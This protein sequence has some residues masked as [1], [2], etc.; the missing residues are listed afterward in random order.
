M[1]RNQ[2]GTRMSG[3]RR[4]AS[5][6]AGALLAVSIGGAAHALTYTTGDYIAVFVKG[7]TD[8]YVDLG[9]NLSSLNN[10]GTFLLPTPA[11]SGDFASGAAGATFALYETNAPF[12]G[13][14]PRGITI[15]TDPSVDPTTFNNKAS[16]ITKVTP[17]QVALDN[18]S[19]AGFLP[20]DVGTSVTNI[21]NDTF[22]L[23]LNNNSNPG[24]VNPN[25]WVS[26]IGANING[27]LPFSTASTLGAG[28]SVEN[29]YS[30]TRTGNATAVAA[31][32]GFFD[33]FADVSTPDGTAVTLT[34]SPIPEPG[35]LLLVA[36]GLTGLIWVGRRRTE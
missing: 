22:R 26:L 12:S 25:S 15:T 35:T 18:G 28:T 24:P 3:I 4:I 7:N 31:P 6:A 1:N 5:I 34:F 11:Q 17:A 8:F 21:L 32:L 2:F 16:L 23:A 13:T 20:V 33:V 14:S 30:V 10:G 9:Q 27:N 36:S 29:L 19:G